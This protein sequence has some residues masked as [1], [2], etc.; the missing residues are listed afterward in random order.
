[1]QYLKFGLSLLLLFSILTSCI[2]NRTITKR[3]VKAVEEMIESSPVFND[4]FTGFVLY[5]PANRTTI[6]STNGDKYF[7]PASN[8]KILS[9]YAAL[10]ILGDSLPVLNYF[11]NED[12]FYFWGTG[13]PLFLHPDFD[14]G[15]EII[16]FL[17]A[18]NKPLRFIN[19]NFRDTRFGDGWMWDDYPYYFQVE[20]S[21][22][23]LY[24][25]AVR[26]TLTPE[27]TTPTIFPDYFE[28][29]SK[30]ETPSNLFYV[31][32]DELVNWFEYHVP[33]KTGKSANNQRGSIC[34]IRS[35][36]EKFVK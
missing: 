21:A 31:T 29:V 10:N 3:E 35:F 25:N 8:T 1:M 14:I 33:K 16:E 32:R 12:A 34:Y 11:E 20:K 24:G 19:D 36:D 5:D 15:S 4:Q 7:T 9:L 17:R 30:Q 22:L 23:P 2:T 18:Q 28:G 13:N 27:T 26:F 6:T